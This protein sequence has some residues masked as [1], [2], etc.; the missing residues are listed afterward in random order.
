MVRSLLEWQ[1]LLAIIVSSP[2]DTPKPARIRRRRGLQEKFYKLWVAKKW[3]A[4][5][6]L[7]YQ[8]QSKLPPMQHRDTS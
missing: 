1:L 4:S 8:P 7:N 5:R 2:S 3:R 6:P